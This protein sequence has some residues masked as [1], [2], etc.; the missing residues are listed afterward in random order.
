M[1]QVVLSWGL[2]NNSEDMAINLGFSGFRRGS[3][4]FYK[5]DW[6]YL[7]DASTRG[8]IASDVYRYIS[9][10]GYIISL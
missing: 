3:Y 1:V 2:F 9:A 7:N 4:D 6:K 5:T 8:E 10:S